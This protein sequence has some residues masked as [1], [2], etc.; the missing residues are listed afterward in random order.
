MGRLKKDHSGWKTTGIWK[1]YQQPSIIERVPNKSKKDRVR[2]CGGKTN[3]EHQLIRYFERRWISFDT[4]SKYKWIKCK[5][6][7][8]G[9]RLHKEKDT[10]IPLHI[11]LD[12]LFDIS[13]KYQIPVKING[14]ILPFK[15]NKKEYIW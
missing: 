12:N 8:C 7:I 4:R 1:K 11:E 13:E 15:K 9:K 5:C 10:S 2:W 3:K 14:V 6:S